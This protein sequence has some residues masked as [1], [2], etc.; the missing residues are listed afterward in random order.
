MN[1][2][3]WGWDHIVFLYSHTYFCLQGF[4][5]FPFK[6]MY[7]AFTFMTSNMNF[8]IFL[9]MSSLKLIFSNA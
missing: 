8:L 9:I 4:F 2:E 3:S 1:V 5:I 7:L 6:N